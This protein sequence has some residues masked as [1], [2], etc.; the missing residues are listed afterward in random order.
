M[1]SDMRYYETYYGI[2]VDDMSKTFGSFSEHHKLLVKEYLSEGCICTETSSASNTNEFLY[3]HHIKRKYFIEGVIKGHITVAAS[4]ATSTCTSFRVSVCKVNEETKDKTEL[5]STG[6]TSI[7]ATLNFNSTYSIG[8][9]RV[10]PF[11]I[12]AWKKATLGEFDRIYV[13]IEVNGS[14]TLSLWHSNDASWEDIKISIPF[15]L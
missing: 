10:I 9:E 5:F 1:S 2:H 13:K 11:E 3:P 4:T 7:N 12:D 8:D 6:W 15:L 14:D